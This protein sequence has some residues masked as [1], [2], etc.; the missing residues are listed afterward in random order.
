MRNILILLFSLLSFIVSFSP[1]YAAPLTIGGTANDWELETN[2]G[3]S[4]QYYTDSEDKVSVIIFWATWCPYCATLMPHLEDV[5][6]KY[7][8]K[9]VK[10]YAIDIYEDGKIDPISYFEKKGF[11]YT[12][13][14]D[15]DEVASQYGVKGTPAVYVIDKEKKV[16]YK[17][18]GGVSDVLVKQNVDLRIKQALAK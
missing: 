12:M 3:D 17:R 13:L 16:V 14:L 10:F 7:R 15:G 9:G 2:G 6:R 4:L 8:N 18:P 1:V 11:S 5:Y